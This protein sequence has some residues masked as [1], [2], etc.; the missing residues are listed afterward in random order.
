M[1]GKWIGTKKLVDTFFVNAHAAL[2]FL[3]N[4]DGHVYVVRFILSS[5]F[6]HDFTVNLN[7]MGNFAKFHPEIN[8]K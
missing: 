5:I 4:L 1:L 7:T 3:C 2:K 8:L 6:I